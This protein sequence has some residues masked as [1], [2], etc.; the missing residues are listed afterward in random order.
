ML[1]RFRINENNFAGDWTPVKARA[2]E[3]AKRYIS[4]NS[5][6]LTYRIETRDDGEKIKSTPVRDGDTGFG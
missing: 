6:A 2:I 1:Y 4:H 5:D 3:E